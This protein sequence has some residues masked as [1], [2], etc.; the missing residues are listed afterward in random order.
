MEVINPAVGA[1]IAVPIRRNGDWAPYDSGL[2]L[3]PARTRQ[4]AMSVAPFQL[5]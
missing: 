3:G 4:D 5:A 1:G 2:A